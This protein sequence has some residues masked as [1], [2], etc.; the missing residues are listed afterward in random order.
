MEKN[1]RF[2]K[3]ML[4]ILTAIMLAM[5]A[6]IVTAD[7]SDPLDP[8]D[9][10][11]DWDGDGLTNAEENDAGTNMNNADSDGDGLPDGWEVNHGLNPTNGGDA[12][13]DPDGDGLT[14]AQEY[15]K[16]TNPNNSDTDG[17]GKPDNTDAYPNDPNDGEYSDSDGDGIPDAYDPDYQ[18]S[19]A[20]SGDGLSLIHI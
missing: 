14:N 16:G 9:G 1:N 15:A 3:T 2:T 5:S 11:A 6:G 10:G 13:A 19:Q 17:D 4:T 7:G 20:G 8:S 18:E 12:N